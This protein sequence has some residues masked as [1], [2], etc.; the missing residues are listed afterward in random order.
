MHEVTS[1][2]H[3][4]HSEMCLR[5]LSDSNWRLCQCC[6]GIAADR[7]AAERSL[8]F[9][10]SPLAVCQIG[11]REAEW[12]RWDHEVMP[13]APLPTH[14]QARG[15]ALPLSFCLNSVSNANRPKVWFK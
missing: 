5:S 3:N 8:G 12:S 2:C 15:A 9:S 7:A 13:P 10:S 1:T 11:P 4:R 6:W 14:P